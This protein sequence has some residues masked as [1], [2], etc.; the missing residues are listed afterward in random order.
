M[1]NLS[2]EVDEHFQSMGLAV[3]VMALDRDELQMNK[4]KK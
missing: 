1:S 2:L 4:G 3:T